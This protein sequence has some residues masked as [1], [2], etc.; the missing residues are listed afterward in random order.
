M[1][2]FPVFDSEAR[3][4]TT[5]PRN[6]FSPSSSQNAPSSK[7]LLSE[8]LQSYAYGT[9]S[10]MIPFPSSSVRLSINIEKSLYTG[11]ENRPIE[12]VSNSPDTTTSFILSP[13]SVSVS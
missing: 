5:S 7:V 12:Y 2:T 13:V 11:T 10:C 6:T 9:Q 3:F 1:L 8:Y 4:S